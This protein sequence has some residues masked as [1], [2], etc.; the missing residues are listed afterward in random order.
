MLMV[1]GSARYDR[2]CFVFCRTF[3]HVTLK[4]RMPRI[5]TQAIDTIHRQQERLYTEHGE[6]GVWQSLI[7]VTK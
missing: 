5:L 2:L 6:V 4:E 1:I 7:Q 3:A